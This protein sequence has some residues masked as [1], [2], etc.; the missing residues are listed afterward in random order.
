MQPRF[1]WASAKKRNMKHKAENEQTVP[2]PI[3]IDPHGM[4]LPSAVHSLPSFPAITFKTCHPTGSVC[5]TSSE[6][7]DSWVTSLMWIVIVMVF[8]LFCSNGN[9]SRAV[10]VVSYETSIASE[11][12]PTCA[13]LLFRGR[14][15]TVRN[16]CHVWE[17]T[18]LDGTDHGSVNAG[19]AGGHQL[20]VMAN[21]S[22][23]GTSAGHGTVESDTDC[24]PRP[25]DFHSSGFERMCSRGRAS[26]SVADGKRRYP[27]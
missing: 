27:R 4:D 3:S 25:N 23:H 19:S 15:G 26:L 10:G 16:G 20:A 24:A 17:R 9:F 22:E 2:R 12:L 5:D 7:C 14:M 6:L 18:M 13:V 1:S 21:I 11:A 8:H